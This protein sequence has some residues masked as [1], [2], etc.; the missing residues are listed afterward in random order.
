[1]KRHSIL[2]AA[3][4]F[5]TSLTSALGA[6]Q[7]ASVEYKDG[8]TVLE[9][10]VAWDD[11]T[12]GPRPGVLVV[13]DW[14]GLQ[15]Y[16]KSRV[17][18]LAEMGYVA[19]AADIYG[20][21][22]RPV[23]PKECAVCAGTYRNDLALLRRRTGAALAALKTRPETDSAHVG[24]IGYCFGGSCVLEMARAGLDVAAVVSFHGGLSTTQ[25]AAPGSIKA[26]IL[27]CHGGADDHVNQEV[28]AFKEE[29]TTARA[30][31][32]FITYEG[33]KH[34]FTKPGAAYQEKADTQSWA[35][36]KHLFAEVLGKSQTH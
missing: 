23:D 19:F 4:A 10:Y 8:E 32:E 3:A 2:A 28:P 6:I 31:M 24:A 26:R 15:D 9:G 20:K 7:T 29:M 27:V 1:M 5:V 16:T 13:H 33:A 21:G 18:Q 12:S 22:V 35:A 17:R 36:M 25:P 30:K 34:G 11:A 14:T